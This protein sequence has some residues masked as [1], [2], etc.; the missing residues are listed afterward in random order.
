[1]KLVS[2]AALDENRVIGK[3]G[4]V[5]WRLPKDVEQYRA[6]V[7]DSPVILGRR[8]HDE[9]NADPAGSHRIVLSRT[10]SDSDDAT[11]TYVSSVEAAIETAAATDSSTAY[12]LGGESI[13]ELFQPHADEMVL[14]RVAGDHDGDS[15]FPSWERDEWRVDNR[16]SYESFTVEKWVRSDRPAVIDVVN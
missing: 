9:M 2:V 12:V 15:Y 3:D 11:T 8:T 14:T 16:T 6:R 7:A 5:P 13:Y 10:R 1:M 4:D